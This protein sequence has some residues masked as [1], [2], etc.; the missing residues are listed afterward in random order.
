V[1][2]PPGT[3]YLGCAGPAG[4]CGGGFGLS[5]GASTV[6]SLSFRVTAPTVGQG[7]WQFDPVRRD[8]VAANNALP[9]LGSLIHVVTPTPT[10]GSPLPSP[11]GTTSAGPRAPTPPGRAP[12]APAPPPSVSPTSPAA[13]LSAAP[14]T[15]AVGVSGTSQPGV[16][17]AAGSP[18]VGPLPPGMGPPPEPVPL[19]SAGTVGDG[20]WDLTRQALLV[21][22]M[23]IAVPLGV[24]SGLAARRRYLD[25]WRGRHSG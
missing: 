12:V 2:A 19:G 7:A 15:P 24:V 18:V 20:L 23:V 4:G 5:P 17:A 8:P 1:T 6:L 10:V 22:A 13:A 11:S 14:I 9:A 21:L 3:E 16:P 25:R